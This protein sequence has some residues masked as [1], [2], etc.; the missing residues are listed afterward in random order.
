MSIW[1]PATSD[2]F[3]DRGL[4]CRVAKVSDDGGIIWADRWSS[5]APTGW[6][7]YSAMLTPPERGNV[8]ASA[9]YTEAWAR[10]NEPRQA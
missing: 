1:I 5:H 4:L 9:W 8:E 2:L 3:L 6:R 7:F 10:R